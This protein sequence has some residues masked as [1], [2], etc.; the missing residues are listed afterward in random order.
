MPK[1]LFQDMVKINSPR[2]PVFKV[3]EKSQMITSRYLLWLVALISVTFL[4]F[5]LSAFFSNAKIT[6]NPKIQNVPFNENLVAGRDAS[7]NNLPFDLVVISGEDSK[8]IQG[9]IEKEVSLKAQGAVMLYNA[10]GSSAQRLDID[11]RLEGSNG[12]LYKTKTKTTVPG[13]AADGAPGSVAVEIYAAEA[14]GEYNSPPLDFKIFGFNGTPKYSKFYGRSKGE[15]TG[16]FKGKS[17]VISDSEKANAVSDLK[18]TL[19]AKLFRKVTDQIPSGFVLLK[20]AIYFNLD[21]ANVAPAST[22]DQMTINVKGTFYGFLF[23]EKKL[24][25]KIIEKLFPNEEVVDVY[26]SNIRDLIFSFATKK[27]LTGET[28]DIDFNLSGDLKVVWKVDE[29]KLTADILGIKKKDFS[30]ILAQYPS[31]IS[32]NLLLHP[33]WRRSIPEN[34]KNIELMVNYPK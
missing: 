12:K 26:I 28:K 29:K 34:A 22:G 19:E 7:A 4:F 16:G 10:F 23:D 14:G 25:K 21:E 3:V 1:N 31:I 24:T 15:I 6:I 11:T 18:A 17:R 8:N 2:Q 32:A 9:E 13:V 20:D 33:F 27:V 5:A 30:Q